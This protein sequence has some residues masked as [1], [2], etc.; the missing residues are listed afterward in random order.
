MTKK[1]IN[2]IS[3]KLKKVGDNFTVTRYDN[4]FMFEVYGQDS[5]DSGKYAKIII[6]SVEDLHVL[7][8]EFTTMERDE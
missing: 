7:V 2:K 1:Q 8:D 5:N 3:D 4:G 6:N